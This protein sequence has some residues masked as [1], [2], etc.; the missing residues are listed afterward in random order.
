[1]LEFIVHHRTFIALAGWTAAAATALGQGS[2]SPVE[3]TDEIAISASRADL[4]SGLAD[5]LAT[6]LLEG[7]ESTWASAM[8]P[9]LE[10]LLA[11]E[12]H[13]QGRA[14]RV[15]LADRRG[16]AA[17]AKFCDRRV[18]MSAHEEAPAERTL[19]VVPSPGSALL[20][21]AG[22]ARSMGRRRVRS[23]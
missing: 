12:P 15:D 3:R 17:R 6:M 5:Q 20:L 18:M 4:L 1:M 10:S 23:S 11:I 22:L 14:V 7:D 13:V 2:G 8:A 16:L 21:L 19:T 9:E